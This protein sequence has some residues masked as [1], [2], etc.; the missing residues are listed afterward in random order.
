M[1]RAPRPPRVVAELGRPETPQETA[2][3]KAANSR[4]YRSSKTVNN[5]IYSL[6]A[7]LA[8]V[9]LMV[10]IVPRS[11]TPLDRTVDLNQVATQAQVGVDQK[12]VNPELPQGWRANAAT[13]SSGGSDKI[14]SWYIGLLTPSNQFI[15]VTQAMD[16]NPT[17]L[18]AQLKNQAASDTVTIDGVTWDVY[19][20]TAP[21]KDR[22]NFDYALATESG[23]S[24]YVLIGTASDA[25]FSDLA[26]LLAPQIQSNGN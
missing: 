1:S 19:R 26:T 18:A 7:T 23:T 24:T 3:R 14:P 2:D 22:G 16:A 8:V 21:A 4:K 17:W 10:L 5:L 6:L 25:E 13:W 15:G 20:N 12:L 11:D 9:V